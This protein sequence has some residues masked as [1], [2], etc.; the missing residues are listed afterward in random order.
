MFMN[1]AGLSMALSSVSV[2]NDVS[3][4][5]L[6]MNL[7][8]LQEMGDAMKKMMEQSVM[9]QLGQNIDVSV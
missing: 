3:T 6:S 1:I 4:A 7:D 2:S 5:V 9:P 8:E